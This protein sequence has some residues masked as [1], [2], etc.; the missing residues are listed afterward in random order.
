MTIIQS[1][2]SSWIL[3]L[4]TAVAFLFAS[5]PLAW[6][7]GEIIDQNETSVTLTASAQDASYTLKVSGK[8]FTESV[9]T[10]TATVDG[11]KYSVPFRA[12]SKTFVLS[13]RVKLSAPLPEKAMIEAVDKDGNKES[14]EVSIPA[15]LINEASL[16]AK[17]SAFIGKDV[18][19]YEVSGIVTDKQLSSLVLS[20]G[21]TEKEVEL[22][23]G[24]FKITLF[25]RDA[26]S[27]TLQ[28]E[29]KDGKKQ[30]VQVKFK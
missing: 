19:F 22:K 30:S 14:I 17:K 24:S 2:Q 18:Y 9:S 16:K 11:T 15:I 8:T 25:E 6:A 23:N 20:I 27:A 3:A 26:D 1:R 4:F 28:A 21:N 5:V 12:K 13:K 7:S 10:I 29:S